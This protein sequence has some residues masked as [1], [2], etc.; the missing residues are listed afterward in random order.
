LDD[1][2]RIEK[3]R[4]IEFLVAATLTFIA[5]IVWSERPLLSSFVAIT[6]GLLFSGYQ[7]AR[8]LTQT[9]HWAHLENDSHL[10]GMKL[11]KRGVWTGN[12]LPGVAALAATVWWGS[13]MRL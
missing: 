7:V 3:Q 2:E 12:L 5:A 6:C 13:A 1:I 11:S 9:H 10:S 4:I 8:R